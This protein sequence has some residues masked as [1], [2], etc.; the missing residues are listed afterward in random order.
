[1][2]D[3]IFVLSTCGSEGEASKVARHLVETRVAAC[4][5]IVPNVRS[6]YRWKG[7]IEESG[8]WMLLIKSSRAEFDKL[9]LELQKVHSYVVPEVI[10]I[11]IVAGSQAYLDWLDR[12][13]GLEDLQP[14]VT[15]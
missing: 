13:L 4:V 9:Q 6:V 5:S 7:A 8:E 11:P 3:K 2:T 15:P 12:E 10:A 14:P 1:M